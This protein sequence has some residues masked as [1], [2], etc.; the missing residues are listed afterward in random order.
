MFVECSSIF[1]P[2]SSFDLDSCIGAEGKEE[3]AKQLQRVSFSS[4]SSV[5]I[6]S[7][8]LLQVVLLCFNRLVTVCLFSELILMF[9]IIENSDEDIIQAHCHYTKALVDGISYDLYD[10]AH[11]QVSFHD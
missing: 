7:F 11:V 9:K 8:S 6:F 5:Y 3:W 10:D 2:L 1:F 4:T